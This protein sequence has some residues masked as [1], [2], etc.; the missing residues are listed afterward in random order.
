ML[1]CVITKIRQ[2]A[3]KAL[4]VAKSAKTTKLELDAQKVENV[5][6]ISG[7]DTRENLLRERFA[8][9]ELANNYTASASVVET[10]SR[11]AAANTVQARNVDQCMLSQAPFISLRS[12]F[13]VWSVG[14][15]VR[16]PPARLC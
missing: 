1:T 12:L 16:D 3:A 6:R 10:A 4:K 2:R 7:Q 11:R 9:T 13:F 8:S 14:T 15:E 5:S